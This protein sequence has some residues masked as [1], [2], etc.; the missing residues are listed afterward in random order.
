MVSWFS[1]LAYKAGRFI[2]LVRLH[3]YHAGLK[4]SRLHTLACFKTWPCHAGVGNRVGQL[5]IRSAGFK[6]G[7]GLQSEYNTHV[8]IYVYSLI[9]HVPRIHD[10]LG[11]Y[12]VHRVP[13]LP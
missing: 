11:E 6:A 13:P 5:E 2:L 9:I 7:A 12:N 10:E 3:K 4:P 1:W 8:Y